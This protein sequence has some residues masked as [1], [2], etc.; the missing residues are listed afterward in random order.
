MT[1]EYTGEAKKA[2][3]RE[4]NGVGQHP[5]YL[6]YKYKLIGSSWI[7]EGSAES[8]RLYSVACIFAKAYVR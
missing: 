7:I 8:Y 2:I 6:V 3:V 5:G 4:Y 1:K